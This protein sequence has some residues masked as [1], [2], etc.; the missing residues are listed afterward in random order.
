LYNEEPPGER[1][2]NFKDFD[3]LADDWLKE[4]FYP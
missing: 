1:V 2:I 3:M 4:S